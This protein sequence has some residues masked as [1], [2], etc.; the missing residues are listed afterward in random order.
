MTEAG[1]VPCVNW[2]IVGVI[3]KKS[4]MLHPK[5]G[6]VVLAGRPLELGATVGYYYGFWV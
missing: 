1:T 6:L 2:S 3:I 4:K 5:A